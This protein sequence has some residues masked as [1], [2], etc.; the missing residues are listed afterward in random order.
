[1]ERKKIM[2][3]EKAA[4]EIVCRLIDA[5]YVES[6]PEGMEWWEHEIS[7]II[8]KNFGIKK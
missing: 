1:M 5:G 8:K 4:Y 2:N 7:E 6:E 3:A